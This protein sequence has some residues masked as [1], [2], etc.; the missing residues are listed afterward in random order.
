[1]RQTTNAPFGKG[2]PDGLALRLGVR[3]VKSKS[4]DLR[5]V[6]VESSTLP[7]YAYPMT[8]HAYFACIYLS[9]RQKPSI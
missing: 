7:G 3:S 5:V 6:T 1:V 8:C 4:A 9:I 2:A